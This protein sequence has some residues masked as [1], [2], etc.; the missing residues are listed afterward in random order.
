MVFSRVDAQE[1]DVV[2]VLSGHGQ[3]SGQPFRRIPLPRPQRAVPPS[4]YVFIAARAH[5]RDELVVRVRRVFV[6]A[7]NSERRWR[8][9]T[10]TPRAAETRA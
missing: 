2:V 1:L 4:S 8:V 7:R 3:A 10:A 5:A 6:D 9:A